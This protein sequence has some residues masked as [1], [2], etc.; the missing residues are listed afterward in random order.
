MNPFR[1]RQ[2]TAMQQGG[3]AAAF[4]PASITGLQ[5]WLDASQ[6]TGLNDGD[7]VATW[8]DLSGNARDYTQGTA[9]KRPTYKTSIRG[10][11]PVV[12]FDG[13]DDVVSR[14]YNST[15]KTVV[16]VCDITGTPAQYATAVGLAPVLAVYRDT[17]NTRIGFYNAAFGATVSGVGTGFL[18]ISVTFDVTTTNTRVDG[19]SGTPVAGAWNTS[20][21]A[22]HVGNYEG[23]GVQP[24]QGDIAHVLHYDTVLSAADLALLED[25]FLTH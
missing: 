18:V 17:S 6:I 3:G 11:L 16:V 10:A 25:Y 15:V 12:R 23:V 8:P 20:F 21:T 5:L 13:L 14:T 7:A 22:G 19:V 9:S 1:R 2:F 24:W 4:S